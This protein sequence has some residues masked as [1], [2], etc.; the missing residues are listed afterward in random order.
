M[1]RQLSHLF[2]RPACD[3]LGKL[4]CSG[5]QTKMLVHGHGEKVVYGVKCSCTLHDEIAL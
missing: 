1:G 4:A 3:V 5:T 2:D